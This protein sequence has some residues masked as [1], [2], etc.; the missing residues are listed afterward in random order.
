[1]SCSRIY[2]DYDGVQHDYIQ[3]QGLVYEQMLLLPQA[4][5]KWKDRIVLWNAVQAREKTKDSRLG[6]Y[7]K[8]FKGKCRKIEKYAK[9][10]CGIK[11]TGEKQ[12]RSVR[13]KLE[14]NRDNIQ[15]ENEYKKQRCRDDE[16]EL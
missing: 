6:G 10:I 9:G 4:L 15:A 5:P 12:R 14:H 16:M 7:G 2:K 13:R 11:G 1:M 3:K 8:A